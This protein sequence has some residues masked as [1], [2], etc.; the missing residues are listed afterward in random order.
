MIRVYVLGHIQLIIKNL[1]RGVYLNR[2][3]H[4]GD[5]EKNAVEQ[6]FGFS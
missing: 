2:T 3:K 5:G 6:A 1:E 4:F